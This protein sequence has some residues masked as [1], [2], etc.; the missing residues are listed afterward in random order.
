LPRDRFL[1]PI[2]RR[3][4]RNKG[5]A[6]MVAQ[7]RCGIVSLTGLLAAG[8]MLVPVPAASA[9]RVLQTFRAGQFLLELGIAECRSSECPIEVR[10]RRDK[11]VVDRVALPFAASSQRAS[12]EPV[13]TTW[14]ADAGR[15]AWATGEENNYVSTAARP[16][17]IASR[18]TALLVS[19]LAGFDHLKRNHLL[20]VPRASKLVVAWEGR[21]GAGPTWSATEI[22]GN[23]GSDRQEV[24]YFYGFFD[25]DEDVSERLDVI[26]LSWNAAAARVRETPLPAR[27]MPLYLLDLGIHDTAVQA[28]NARAASTCLSSYWVLDAGRFR[29]GAGGKAIVGRLYA[30]R[31]AAYEAARSVRRCLPGVTASIVRWTAAP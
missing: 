8:L 27:T 14:G 6:V 20:L 30:R 16:L 17:R 15:K 10:L 18:T 13:D 21:E 1:R 24:A 19:Q 9:D 7:R 3:E 5:N 11:R 29:A 25:P 2:G 28:R 22:V 31:A 26:R 23:P 12:I 4:P